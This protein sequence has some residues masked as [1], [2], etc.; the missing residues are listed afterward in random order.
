M[1]EFDNKKNTFS[2]KDVKFLKTDKKSEKDKNTI[3]TDENQKISAGLKKLNKNSKNEKTGKEEDGG[4]EDTLLK[5]PIA[6]PIWLSISEAAKIGGVTTKTVRRAIQSENI[7]YKIYK[8]KYLVGLRSLVIF[9][10]SNT[11]LRNKLKFNGIGQYIKE[12]RK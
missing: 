4:V 2:Q 1:T 11:K 9:L 3:N 6:A 7:K 10:N 5:N 8:N 12:W